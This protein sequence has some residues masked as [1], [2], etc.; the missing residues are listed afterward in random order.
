MGDPKLFQ[1]GQGKAV[2]LSGTAMTLE[3][4]LQT[5][6]EHNM[7]TL[8]G[9]RCLASE[10]STG[11]KHGGRMD[12]LGIDENG[13]PVIFEYKRAVNENVITQGLFYLDWLMDHR[14]DFELLVLK[15]L[16]P[17]VTV[18]WSNPRLV[19]VAGDFTRYDEHAIGQM[20]RSTELVRYRSYDDQL[21]ALELVASTTAKATAAGEP[22]IMPTSTTSSMPK[23]VSQLHAAA[24][25]K[26]KDAYDAL[27]Q[28]LLN[29][30]DDVTKIV[31]K[32][33]YAFRRLKNFACVE[34]HPQS[35]KLLVY[36]KVNPDEVTLEEKFFRDVRSIGH[37]GT[38]DLELSLTNTAD[39][40]RAQPLLDLSYAAS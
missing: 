37:F 24:S 2:E 5:L 36:V 17:T 29:L 31:N 34:V 18:D 13:N 14:G 10:Y 38:G 6:I 30:G 27:E 23:T 19:C 21:L 3:K 33:Y 12:S 1:L 7:E 20:N 8:F 22:T 15:Q 16:G 28:Y 11:K 39:V 9:V 4:S 25:P 32:N 35:G 26:L 40:T